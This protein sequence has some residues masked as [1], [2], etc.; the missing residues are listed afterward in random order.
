M[1]RLQAWLELEVVRDAYGNPVA[2]WVGVAY[3]VALLIAL[4]AV[5]FG[6]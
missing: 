1:R 6:S 5:Y 3:G 2:N 4:L